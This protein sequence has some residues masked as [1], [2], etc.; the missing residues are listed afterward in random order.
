MSD[1]ARRPG[2][3]LRPLKPG[4]SVQVLEW[5]S[6]LRV[7]WADAGLSMNEFASLNPI[8]KGTVSRYLNGQRVPRDRWFLDKLLDIRA[9]YGSPVTPAVRDHLIGLHLRALETAHPHEYRIRLVTDQLEIAVASRSESERYARCLEQLLAERSGQVQELADDEGCLRSTL[10]TDLM[11]IRVKYE[12]L[13]AEVVK[14][15][16]ELEAAR[17]REAEADSRCQYFEAI[18]D[19]LDS[20]PQGDGN[21]IGTDLPRDDATGADVGGHAGHSA[22]PN[23]A[24]EPAATV[25]GIGNAARAEVDKRAREIV[26]LAIQRVAGKQTTESVVTVLDLPTEEMKGRIIG[27]E[28]RNIRAFESVTGVNVII[29]DTPEA[30]LLS[31]FDPVRREVARLTLERLL[32][33]GRIDPQRIEEAYEL[34]KKEIELLCKRAGEDAVIQ[35]GITDMHPELINLLGRLKYRTS[36][37]QNVLAHLVE[38]AHIAGMMAAELRMEPLL[39][40]RCAVLH[41]IG[42]ALTHE[43]GGSHA[44][45]GAEIARKYGESEDVAHAIEAHHDEVETRTAEAAL[46]QAANAISGGR[47]GARR[48]SLELYV[49]RLQRL[50]E[51]ARQR[52]REEG[53]ESVFAMQAGREIKVIVKP[54]IVDDIQSEVMAIEIAKQIEEDLDYPGQ[55]RVTLVRGSRA[56]IEFA[57]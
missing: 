13:A 30:V 2:A 36:H 52:E 18:L 34:G 48:E 5:V 47:P 8:D 16:R 40:K 56:V 11:A 24:G 17:E 22:S 20:L 57:S 53:V 19:Q 43:V 31:C 46:T 55:I 44:L 25:R 54:D 41:D 3:E 9:T 42:K 38:S 51:I 32:A 45:I 27:R 28:G 39:L 35:L 21:G 12:C 49:K 50:E 15:T 6:E 37:G 1:I 33:D 7:I 23:W 4:L 14:I 26:A 10:D 29:D